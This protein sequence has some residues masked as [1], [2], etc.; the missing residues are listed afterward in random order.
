MFAALLTFIRATS[1]AVPSIR[2]MREKRCAFENERH[3]SSLLG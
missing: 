3:S 2:R 1:K